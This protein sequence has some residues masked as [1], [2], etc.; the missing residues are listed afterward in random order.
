MASKRK[1]LTFAELDNLPPK[2]KG[3]ILRSAEEVEAERQLLTSDVEE[4]SFDEPSSVTSAKAEMQNYAIAEMQNSTIPPMS[5]AAKSERPSPSD[6]TTYAK[7]SYRMHPDAFDAIT[8]TK[9]ILRRQYNL[10]VSF[11]EIAEQAILIV[12]ND[13]IEHGESSELVKAL[14]EA[15]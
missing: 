8:D 12:Y 11:E 13:L 5:N 1:P 14:R 2:G 6:R 3:A 10:G 7:A 4:L 15:Q 9:R